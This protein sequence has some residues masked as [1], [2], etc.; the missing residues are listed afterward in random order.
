[1]SFGLVRVLR[2]NP[3]LFRDRYGKGP[4]LRVNKR[5]IHFST[6]IVTGDQDGPSYFDHFAY[7]AMATLGS[8]LPPSLRDPRVSP[9]AERRKHLHRYRPAFLWNETDSSKL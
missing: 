2:A 6:Q 9:L 8:Q 7:M 4:I 5:A 3:L 1:M